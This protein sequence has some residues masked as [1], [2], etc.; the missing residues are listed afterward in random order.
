MFLTSGR[1]L[2]CRERRA[3]SRKSTSLNG[4]IIAR[5]LLFPC[6]VVDCSQTGAKLEFD[7]AVMLSGNAML[8]IEQY[9]V[10]VDCSVVWRDGSYMGVNFGG[11]LLLPA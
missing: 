6:R 9:D 4:F 2:P 11:P 7:R 3:Q 8:C 10:D 5:E 1:A